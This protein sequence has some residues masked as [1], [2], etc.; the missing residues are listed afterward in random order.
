MQRREFCKS[1]FIGS[2]LATLPGTFTRALAAE[3]AGSAGSD[4]QAV[5]LSGEPTPIPAAAVKELAAHLRGKLLT[6]SDA[7]YDQARRV[8]NEQ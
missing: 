2:A 4:L 5:G 1:A 7:E 3:P 8:W 6:A